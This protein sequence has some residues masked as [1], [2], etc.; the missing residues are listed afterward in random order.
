MA[1]TKE[2]LEDAD[3]IEAEFMTIMN[4]EFVQHEP[5]PEY[6]GLPADWKPPGGIAAYTG[7]GEWKKSAARPRME[8]FAALQQLTKHNTCT[9]GQG[10]QAD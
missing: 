7:M 4:E 2:M 1:I 9:S 5:K 6:Y 10:L 8:S 3:K